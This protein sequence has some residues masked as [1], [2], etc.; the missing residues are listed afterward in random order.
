MQ[1]KAPIYAMDSNEHIGISFRLE[2]GT[3][4]SMENSS[5]SSKFNFLNYWSGSHI[6]LANHQGFMTKP[7]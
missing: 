2:L 6:S 4:N 1:I 7:T 5:I 3:H